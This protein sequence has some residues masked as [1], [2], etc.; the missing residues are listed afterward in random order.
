M[1]SLM[2][3]E[4]WLYKMKKVL[5]KDYDLSNTLRMYLITL[6]C[7]LKSYYGKLYTSVFYH[8]KK[9]E[10]IVVI[11]TSKSVHPGKMPTWN[12]SCP[13]IFLQIVGR[14][15][16]KAIQG[17]GAPISA[18]SPLTQYAYWMPAIHAA[19]CFGLG[20]HYKTWYLPH[21]SH[22]PWQTH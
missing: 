21:W 12:K 7:T 5:E 8:N 2:D 11:V 19:S 14:S 18:L 15:P 17:P 6:N 16:L 13:M 22:T 3:I 9:W 20:W 1:W 10:K 4:L